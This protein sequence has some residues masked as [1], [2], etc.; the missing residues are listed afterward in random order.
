[1]DQLRG[2]DLAPEW[3][4]HFR[5]GLMDHCWQGSTGHMIFEV[6]VESLFRF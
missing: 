6:L 4:L 5:A 1:M 3:K 2:T